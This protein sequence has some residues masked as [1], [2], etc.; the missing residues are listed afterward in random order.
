MGEER[1]VW[2]IYVGLWVREERLVGRPGRPEGGAEM[3]VG[4]DERYVCMWVG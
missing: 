4:R 3:S 2:L 1:H